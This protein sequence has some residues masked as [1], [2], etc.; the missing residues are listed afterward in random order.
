MSDEQRNDGLHPRHPGRGKCAVIE[1]ESMDNEPEIGGFIIFLPSGATKTV[2]WRCTKPIT[3]TLDAAKDYTAKIV[4]SLLR[5]HGAAAEDDIRCTN[6]TSVA[7]AIQRVIL[8]WND[9]IVGNINAK[10]VRDMVE[11]TVITS[12]PRDRRR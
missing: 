8:D 3:P 2:H 5:Q 6:W 4:D 10:M 7:A 1:I 9:K 12:G 11:G